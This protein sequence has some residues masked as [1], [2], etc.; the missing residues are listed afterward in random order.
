MENETVNILETR[1]A[2]E[3]V[4]A[5]V[6]GALKKYKIGRDRAEDIVMDTMQKHPGFLRL[7]GTAKGKDA[8]LKRISKTRGYREVKSKARKRIYYELRQYNENIALRESLI[9]SLDRAAARP[10][11]GEYRSIIQQLAHTHISTK[12]RLNHLDYFYDKLFDSVGE[13]HSIVDVGCGLHPLLFP[14]AEREKGKS[15]RC[16]AALDKD[17]LSIAALS[18]FSRIL[19]GNILQPLHWDIKDGWR[20]VLNT[21]NIP[22]FDVAFLMKLV[23]VVSRIERDLMEILR[24]TPA[25]T[26]VIT[27]SRVSMTKY[28]GIEQ[29][30]RRIIHRFIEESGRAVAGEFST[31]EEFC[32]IVKG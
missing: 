24:E 10:S 5:V 4:A 8:S 22:R 2:V 14:F 13:F 15:V 6:E 23:P 9:D 11:Q 12:E 30:E 31:P 27:G 21:V 26:W 29:R 3:A 1:L 20:A 25:G 7:L 19:G 28:A 32:M 16:Y 17:P 18:A